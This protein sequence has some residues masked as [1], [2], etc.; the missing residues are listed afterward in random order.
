MFELV[1]PGLDYAAEHARREQAGWRYTLEPGDFY[2]DAFPCLGALRAAG[3][4]IGIAGNQPEAAETSLAALG[5]PAD[6]IA[7]SARWG[8]E[9]PD[10]AFFAKAVDAAGVPAGAIAYVGDRLDNDVLPARA[11]GMFS[12]FI[13]RGPWG[14]IQAASPQAAEAD[15]RLETLV[16][17]AEALGRID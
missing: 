14:V 1:R 15:L 6:F 5:V 12:V 3:F 13:R 2:P 10:P 9:K 7:S 4:R 16:G 17:L 8:V 11:A